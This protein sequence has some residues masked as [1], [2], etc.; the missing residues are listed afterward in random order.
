MSLRSAGLR[1]PMIRNVSGGRWIA[2]CVSLII[3]PLERVHSPR[4][5]T[6][7][8]AGL[9]PFMAYADYGRGEVKC[10][11]RILIC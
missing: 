4:N 8:F 3:Q 6:W 7:T 11:A 10:V 2:N 5:G 1:V 9:L